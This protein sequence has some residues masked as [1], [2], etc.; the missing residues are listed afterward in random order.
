MGPRVTETA[1][2]RTSTPLRM[3]ALPSLENLISLC[4][5]RFKTGF[6]AFAA[7]RRTA[8]EDAALD[9]RCMATAD[10]GGDDEERVRDGEQETF[11]DA[12]AYVCPL[13]HR[14]V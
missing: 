11:R 1:L 9:R 4:A 10:D 8:E 12:T 5:P 7:L 13:E 3:E 14:T 6:A 2:A